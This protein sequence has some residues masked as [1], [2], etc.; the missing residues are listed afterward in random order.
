[1][2]L[3]LIFFLAG[4]IIIGA[5]MF[6]VIVKLSKRGRKVLNVE[7]YRVKY[8]EIEN[9]LKKDN[10]PS[11]HFTVLSADK[12]VD[13]ALKDRGARGDTMGERMKNLASLFSDRNDIWTA[14]KLRNKIA[15]ESDIQVSYGEARQALAGFKKALKDL[16]AI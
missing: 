14:H 16:G 2:D 12:L 8:L 13:Q 3:V 9:Q 11:Y 15:H 4:I 5:L 10:P 1:M 6:A 7:H